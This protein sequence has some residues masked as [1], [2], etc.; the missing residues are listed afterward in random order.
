[1]FRID[2]RQPSTCQ[3]LAAETKYH[4]IP[5]RLPQLCTNYHP[6]PSPVVWREYS[7][8]LKHTLTLAHTHTCLSHLLPFSHPCSWPSVNSLASCLVISSPACSEATWLHCGP[9]RL[10][11]LTS[12]LQVWGQRAAARMTVTRAGLQPA[13]RVPLCKLEKG[14]PLGLR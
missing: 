3:L 2:R 11:G 1:M 13:H 9:S 7:N 8:P 5:C 14:A 6:L 10:S 4:Q 12:Q